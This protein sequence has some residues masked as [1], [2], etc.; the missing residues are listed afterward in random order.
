[1][2]L[3]GAAH[4]IL[5]ARSL[6]R[7]VHF[8]AHIHLVVSSLS[9]NN[10]QPVSIIPADSAAPINPPSLTFA[11]VFL[12]FFFRR[13]TALDKEQHTHRLAPKPHQRSL[14][15]KV[16]SKWAALIPPTH[17]SMWTLISLLL[18][19]QDIYTIN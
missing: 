19:L 16:Y 7:L 1:M 6:S 11:F 12:L 13:S 5:F 10:G 4:S 2:E 9:R 17:I 3:C 14:A 18:L 8:I 15:R